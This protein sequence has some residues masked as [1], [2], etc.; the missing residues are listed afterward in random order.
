METYKTYKP[1][2][3]CNCECHRMPGVYHCIPCC[4]KPTF[5]MINKIFEL[6]PLKEKS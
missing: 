4:D 1:L 6:I 5:E 2:F 3:E